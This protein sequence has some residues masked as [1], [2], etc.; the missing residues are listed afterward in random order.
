MGVGEPEEGSASNDSEARNPKDLLGE[1]DPPAP[2]NPPGQ[3][4]STSAPLPAGPWPRPRLG[5]TKQGEKQCSVL[6]RVPP[7]KIQRNHTAESGAR[8]GPGCS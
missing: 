5:F 3:T 7:F 8:T 4:N 2:N 6:V 1:H